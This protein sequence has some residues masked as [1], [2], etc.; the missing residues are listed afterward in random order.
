MRTYYSVLS[1]E[2]VELVSVVYSLE[3]YIG[4]ISKTKENPIQ[5]IG[6]NNQLDY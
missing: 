3:M 6:L 4:G 1:Q 5:R 2:K